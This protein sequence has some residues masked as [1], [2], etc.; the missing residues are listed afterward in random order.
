MAKKNVR[1]HFDAESHTYS[2]NGEVLPSVTQIL[3]AA[4]VTTS[5]DNV[6]DKEYYLTLGTYVHKATELY[7]MNDLDPKSLTEDIEKYLDGWRKFV[8][9]SE[10]KA[11]MIEEQLAHPLYR[12]AGTLDRHGEC[13]GELTT[14]DIKTG[15]SQPE[16]AIQLAAY[17]ELRCHAYEA[18]PAVRLVV[19]L[20][21]DGSYRLYESES[22]HVEDLSMF[23]SCLQVYN[24]KKEHRRLK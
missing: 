13:F 14:L 18:E 6:K 12:Y 24:W 7:D 20:K 4:G 9:D 8:K 11:L 5:Y 15:D 22:S 10:F 17:E 1:P 16:H 23:L 3:K 2:L 19:Q 21:D